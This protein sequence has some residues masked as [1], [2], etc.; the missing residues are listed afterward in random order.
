MKIIVGLGNPG[1]EY[2]TTRHNA[3]C[4]FVDKLAEVLSTK[5]EELSDY[6][7]RRKKTIMVWESHD[8][9]WILVKTAGVF[10]N[11]SGRI[12]QELRHTMGI[13]S[14][15][16][17]HSIDQLYVAHDDLDIKL[18]EY[19]IQKGVGPK[20]HNG[21]TAV[22]QALGTKDFWRIRI[23]IENRQRPV[24]GEEYVLQRFSLEERRVVGGAIEKIVGRL[25]TK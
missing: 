12:I 9:N 24:S 11:E 7:W 25:L 20:V 4:Q 6:G 18:G 16:D 22:E 5:Y 10:M 14:A 21:V 23:G 19:K 2:A 3:G 13:P 15:H 1:P 17:G 8:K